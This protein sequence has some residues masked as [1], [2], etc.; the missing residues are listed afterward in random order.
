MRGLAKVNIV[1]F[2]M[3]LLVSIGL[4]SCNPSKSSSV[5][6]FIKVGKTYEFGAFGVKAEVLEIDN[7]GWIK[8]RAGRDIYWINLNAYTGRIWEVEE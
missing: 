2:L 4:N 7:S 8:I 1:A 6:S 5:P 3:V